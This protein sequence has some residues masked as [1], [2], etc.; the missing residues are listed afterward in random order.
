MSDL[1]C[2]N[3]V[4][5]GEALKK[6]QELV[7]LLKE[8]ESNTVGDILEDSSEEAIIHQ[9]VGILRR[10]IEAVKDIEQNTIHLEK[11]QQKN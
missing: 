1:V 3:Q 8:E 9:A 10:R 5:V 2:S 4:S 7:M 11:P 6:P